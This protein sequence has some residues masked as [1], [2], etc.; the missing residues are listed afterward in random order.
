MI[1]FSEDKYIIELLSEEDHKPI[2]L[3]LFSKTDDLP[4]MT[5]IQR[6]VYQILK[7]KSDK[8]ESK[9]ER[10][11]IRDSKEY[12]DWRISVFQRD[13]FTCA[14]CGKH[15][16]DIHAHHLNAFLTHKESRLDISNGITLCAQCHRILHRQEV[17]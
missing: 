13:Q 9:Y 8:V 11:R 7:N 3:A 5:D 15:G 10:K 12:S 1:I 14:H 17:V 16:G 6:I 2:L 4:E